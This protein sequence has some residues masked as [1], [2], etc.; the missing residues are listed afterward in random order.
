[1]NTGA[2]IGV[3]SDTHGKLL[4]S[5][6]EAFAEVGLILHAGDIGSLDV[7]VELETIATVKAVTGNMDP[8]DLRQFHPEARIV[9]L[10]GMRALMVHGHH[11]GEARN[12]LPH[13]VEAAK[14]NDASAVIYG[15][16]HIPCDELMDGVRIFNPGSAT[17]PRGRP[18]PTVGLL[19]FDGRSVRWELVSLRR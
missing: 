11:F 14:A 4:A 5:V 7:L 16:S 17:Q 3:I 15:H 9:E 13:L 2:T 12:R 18:H 8:I 10:P 19:H 6:H 1:M